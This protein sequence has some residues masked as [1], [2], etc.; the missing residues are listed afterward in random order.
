MKTKRKTIRKEDKKG[1]RSKRMYWDD[2]F[3]RIRK[4]TH[5]VVWILRG[6]IRLSQV[7]AEVLHTISLLFDWNDR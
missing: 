2:R 6:S 7:L 5:D 3:K 1:T 4:D